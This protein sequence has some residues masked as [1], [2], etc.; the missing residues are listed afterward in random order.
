MMLENCLTCAAVGGCMIFSATKSAWIRKHD[1]GGQVKWAKWFQMI[2]FFSPGF[3]GKWSN[4]TCAYLS[5][6]DW[7]HPPTV[8]SRIEVW[9]IITSVL[10]QMHWFPWRKGT[11]QGAA[12]VVLDKFVFLGPKKKGQTKFHHF[13]CGAGLKEIGA[14]LFFYQN[15]KTQQVDA[16]HNRGNLDLDWDI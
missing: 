7:F 15:Q 13:F 12:V 11:R 4:L 3:L 1:F 16:G 8:V 9:W 10:D 2:W 5:G 6:S 14:D